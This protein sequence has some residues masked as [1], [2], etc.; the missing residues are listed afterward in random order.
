MQH[1]SNNRILGTMTRTGIGARILVAAALAGVLSVACDVHGVTAPGTLVS[2]SV[3]PNATLVA[4]ST[5]QMTAIGYDADGRVIPVSPTWSIAAGGGTIN[6]SGIFTAGTV[7]GLFSKTVVASVGNITASASMTVLPGVLATISIL[8]TPV[9]LAVT[10]TQ[11]FV[12]V[13]KDISG[14][15]VTFVPTW[16][17]VANGG[18]ITQAGVFT[19]GGTP[20]TYT[21]TVQAS[22]SGITAFATV[23]VTIGPL[24]SISVTPNPDT[25]IVGAKQQF[26]AV[27]K[28]VSGNAVAVAAVWSVAAAGGTVD[29]GG[30]FTAGPLPGTY[31]NTVKATSGSLSG[32]ATVVVTAG[33]L[34]TIT[35]TPNPATMVINSTQQFTAVGKDAAGNVV[36]ITPVWAVVA[37]S[38]G[39][40]ITATGLY[41]AGTLTG[42]FTNKV[43]ASSGTGSSLVSGFATIIATAGPLTSIIVTPNPVYMPTNSLQQFVAQGKDASG[44]LFTIKP[45]W[46]VVNGGGVIDTLGNFTSGGLAGTFNNT[47]Q[48]ALGAVQGFATVTISIPVPPS[49]VD[50]GAAT[51]AGI[52]ANQS[53]TCSSAG[54]IN[55]D[56]MV[57]PGN[58]LTGFGAG[59]CTITGTR[60]LADGV[61]AQALI[62]AT[63]AYNTLMGL[64]CTNAIVADLGSTTLTPGVYCTNSTIGV[65]GHGLAG[66]TLDA[67]NN[68]N[69]TFVFQA[70]TVTGAMTTAGDINLKNGAQAKNVYW[71][72]GTSA[73]LGTGSL[74]QGNIV[75][76]QS[77]TLVTGSTLTG[78][79]LALNGSVVLGTGNT[80]TLP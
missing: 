69:A 27:G 47:I 44:N 41:T 11:Q 53:V 8:P 78:R 56:V 33:P 29:G 35:V 16:S 75:A 65:T 37:T 25:L 72:I 5:Q 21:N 68:P 2:M 39:A 62:D 7:P 14:N 38:N 57:S 32:T 12:A 63:N 51:T 40:S 50:F 74:F 9:T 52:F 15:I 24:A 58:T 36:A 4:S 31:T 28:D 42:T 49:L 34:A 64:P 43:R 67:Q 79:A 6:S 22:N 17:V 26:V 20:G 55:A 60:H 59:N 1:I 66:L 18:A 77:I 76:N 70:K 46:S 54:V 48:A 71:V 73:T 80:I 61:A 23:I 19:A 30:I 3:T 13:G 45:V 10:G